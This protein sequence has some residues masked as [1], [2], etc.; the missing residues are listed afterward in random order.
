MMNMIED[1]SIIYGKIGELMRYEPE[2]PE[3]KYLWRKQ[4]LG[5]DQFSHPHEDDDDE[6]EEE[7]EEEKEDL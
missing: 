1:A 4:E 3:K 7:E 2:I 6:E 5:I